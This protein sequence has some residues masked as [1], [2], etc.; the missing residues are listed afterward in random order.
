[1]VQGQFQLQRLLHAQPPAALGRALRE[2]FHVLYQPRG[3]PLQWLACRAMLRLVRFQRRPWL[4]ELC[5]PRLPIQLL[6]APPVGG[7]PGDQAS[8]HPTGGPVRVV[9]QLLPIRQEQTGH[10]ISEK[11]PHLNLSWKSLLPKVGAAMLKKSLPK[12]PKLSRSWTRHPGA[13][14]PVETS[15]KTNECL[16]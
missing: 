4:A 6:P 11:R 1:M 7:Q 12:S 2:V 10:E 5:H 16:A 9:G 14:C 3:P 15:R 8:G 13:P